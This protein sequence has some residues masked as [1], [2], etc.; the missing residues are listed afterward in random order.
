MTSIRLSL[1]WSRAY[2]DMGTLALMFITFNGSAM[3]FLDMT[4]VSRRSIYSIR[5][6]HAVHFV[7][8]F[9]NLGAKGVCERSIHFL[10]WVALYLFSFNLYLRVNLGRWTKIGGLILTFHGDGHF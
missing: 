7:I 2:G 10:G 5:Y 6:H 1:A 8:F 9:S 4:F 3:E